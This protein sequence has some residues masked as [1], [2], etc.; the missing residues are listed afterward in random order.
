MYI[1]GIDPSQVWDSTVDPDFKLGQLGMDHRGTVWMFLEADEAIDPMDVVV[2]QN[3]GGALQLT[4]TTGAAGTGGGM[5]LAV[6]AETQSQAI[7]A[8]DH[9]WGCVFAPAVAGVKAN[10]VASVDDFVELYASG[11]DGHLTDVFD[12]DVAV[13]GIVSTEGDDVEPVCAITWPTVVN[14]IDS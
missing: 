6:V 9:F 2:V 11:T 1:L 14:T 3:D 7:A 13:R 5:Q 8:G 4:A 12:G 10:A